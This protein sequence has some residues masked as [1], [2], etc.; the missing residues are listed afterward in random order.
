MLSKADRSKA[1]K[2]LLTAKAECKPALQLSKTFPG[3]GIEDA[4]PIQSEV[5]KAKAL[6]RFCFGRDLPSFHE[7][8]TPV[9]LV[10]LRLV[11]R[12]SP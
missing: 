6:S 8:A 12:P 10:P 3:I 7:S 2:F 4:H 5:T 9:Q 11:E 1:A